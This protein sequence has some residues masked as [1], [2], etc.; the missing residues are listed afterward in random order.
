MIPIIISDDKCLYPESMFS[1]LFDFMASHSRHFQV[2]CV[3]CPFGYCYQYFLGIFAVFQMVNQIKHQNLIHQFFSSNFRS[4]QAYSLRALSRLLQYPQ[5]DVWIVIPYLNIPITH[6]D[7]DMMSHAL[8]LSSCFDLFIRTL[9]SEVS[10]Q[11]LC[12]ESH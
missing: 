5:N 7:F 10:F 3:W 1:F 2:M 4:F 12:D 11:L 9:T 6:H 8:N